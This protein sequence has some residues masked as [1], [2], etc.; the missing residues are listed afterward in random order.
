[1]KFR[2]RGVSFLRAESNGF[3]LLGCLPGLCRGGTEELQLVRDFPGFLD[4]LDTSL[5]FLFQ[6]VN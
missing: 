6:G 4:R 2:C 1:M 3:L 5:G